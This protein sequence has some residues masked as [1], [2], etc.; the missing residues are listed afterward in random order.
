MCQFLSGHVSGCKVEMLLYYILNTSEAMFYQDYRLL[1]HEIIL[2]DGFWGLGGRRGGC[3]SLQGGGNG[4][5]GWLGKHIV[6]RLSSHMG[7]H[8]GSHMG[9]NMGCHT[10]G[11]MGGSHKKWMAFCVRSQR[12]PHWW[13]HGWPCLWP[14]GWPHGPKVVTLAAKWVAS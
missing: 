5:W 1:C 6:S 8:I 3:Q 12:R 9:G 11:H 10:G 13:P 14:H 4:K 2:F 7:S